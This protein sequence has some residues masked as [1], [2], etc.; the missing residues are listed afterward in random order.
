MA[1]VYHF[2]REPGTFGCVR[3]ALAGIHDVAAARTWEWLGVA[4]RER[5][6]SLCVVDLASISLAQGG[7]EELVA[8]RRRFPS[9]AFV[10]LQR[11]SIDPRRLLD[12]GRL[13]FRSLVL[14][15]YE[16][17]E[18]GLRRKIERAWEGTVASKVLRAVGAK[19]PLREARFLGEALDHVHECW[20][21]EFLAERVGL[22]RPFLSVLLRRVGLPSAGRLLVWVRLLHAAQW[23]GDP[24]RT[25]QSV[26]RQLEY[27]SG[28]A[29]RRVLK[30]FTGAT[31]TL[32]IARGGMP[33]VLRHF[34]RE[35]GF[36][37]A[38]RERVS[39]RVGTGVSAGV[40]AGTS[41][42]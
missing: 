36:D 15:G 29:F 25:G 5:P 11:G 27:S 2:S 16:G 3:D 9:V 30:N 22:S 12:L 8:L 38:V 32:V 39:A 4:L 24:G 33:F 20:S 6:V 23:L 31:P 13:G 19:L 26:S 17:Q 28:A 34:L 1:L 42:A 35:T 14:M 7:C 41:V 18:W 10:L 37:Q 21:A 40:S